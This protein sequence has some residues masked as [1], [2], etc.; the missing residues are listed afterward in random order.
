MLCNKRLRGKLT[1]NS[2]IGSS[3]IRTFLPRGVLITRD[4]RTEKKKTLLNGVL[5]PTDQQYQMQTGQ[6]YQC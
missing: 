3:E 6:D 2:L 1:L 4:L 5:A